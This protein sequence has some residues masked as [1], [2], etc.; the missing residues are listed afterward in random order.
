MMIL[1]ELLCVFFYVLEREGTWLDTSPS[2][3]SLSETFDQPPN[4]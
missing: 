2:D 3:P 1:N 4:F